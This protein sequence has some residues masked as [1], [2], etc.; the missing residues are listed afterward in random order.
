MRNH[1]LTGLGLGFMLMGIGL[2]ALTVRKG[3]TLP[4]NPTKAQV[5]EQAER[6]EEDKKMRLGAVVVAALGLVMAIL[7][8][9]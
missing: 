2:Y 7:G 6:V 4:A 9:Y 5:R 3:R 1:A 8:T